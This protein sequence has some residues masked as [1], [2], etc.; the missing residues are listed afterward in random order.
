MSDLSSELVDIR[1]SVLSVTGQ[2]DIE[3]VTHADLRRRGLTSLECL[4]LFKY[5]T[6]LDLFVV[7]YFPILTCFYII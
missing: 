4:A 7:I 5:L 3:C 2:Y 6:H 1:E